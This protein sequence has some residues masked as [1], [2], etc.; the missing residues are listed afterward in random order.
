MNSR[1]HFEKLVNLLT[2]PPVL[3]YPD[4]NLSLTLHTDASDQGL[5]A[6]LYQHQDGKLRVIGYGSRTVTAVEKNI[7]I[8][9]VENWS[10]LP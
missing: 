10:F 7:I 4:F 6:V 1:K 2:N 9:T 5:G 3:A 8:C